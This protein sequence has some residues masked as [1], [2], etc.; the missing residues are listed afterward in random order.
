MP[1]RGGIF[2]FES[3]GVSKLLALLVALALLVSDTAAGLASGLAGS[4]ALAAATLLCAL[5]KVAGLDGLDMLHDGIT[6]VKNAT[7]IIA[8][9]GFLVNTFGKKTYFSAR[10]A[11]RPCENFTFLHEREKIDIAIFWDLW[12][13]I[14]GAI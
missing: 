4:L 1:P 10:A 6:S 9:N 13:D 12:Y 3:E 5:A 2:Y 11:R 7:V 8:Q 14:G